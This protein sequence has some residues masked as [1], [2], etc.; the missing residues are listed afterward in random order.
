M[1]IKITYFTIC[2]RSR[3]YIEWLAKHGKWAIRTYKNKILNNLYYKSI[4]RLNVSITVANER[5]S[6]LGNIFE[7]MF[8][9]LNTDIQRDGKYGTEARDREG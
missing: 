5:I 1:E 9:Q 6:Q 4:H 8:K 3:Y 2:E 7:E